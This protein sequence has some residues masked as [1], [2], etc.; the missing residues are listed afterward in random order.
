[1]LTL[2][3]VAEEDGALQEYDDDCDGS[4]ENDLQMDGSCGQADGIQSRQRADTD[5]SKLRVTS[6]EPKV[7]TSSLPRGSERSWGKNSHLDAAKVHKKHQVQSESL[8]FFILKLDG[9]QT[10]LIRFQLWGYRFSRLSLEHHNQGRGSS[11]TP[12]VAAPP[13]TKCC[14]PGTPRPRAPM[15]PP[16]GSD[17]SGFCLLLASLRP[18]MIRSELRSAL[19]R[20]PTEEA[21]GSASP[22]QPVG[23]LQSLIAQRMQ[24]AQELLEEMRLQVRG[25]RLRRSVHVLKGSKT[26]SDSQELQKAKVERERG[27]GSPYLKGVDSPRLHHLRGAD[28]AHSRSV[29]ESTRVSRTLM[30]L[31]D[32]CARLRL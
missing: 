26:G 9:N 8:L 3:L 2:D 11:R 20:C 4:W 15:L 32:P 24:R 14:P 29:L 21:A 16:S 10:D 25:W 12:G 28:S 5:V 7:K 22:V 6:K 27:G 1:M 17:Q 23:Q 18:A 31:P 30:F 13:W 19:R